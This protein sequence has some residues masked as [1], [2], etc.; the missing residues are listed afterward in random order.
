MLNEVTPSLRR[1]CM[2]REKKRSMTWCIGLLNESWVEVHLVQMLFSIVSFHLQFLAVLLI[3]LLIITCRFGSDLLCVSFFYLIPIYSLQSILC[4][5][6]RVYGFIG[7]KKADF[8]EL[9]L[10]SSSTSVINSI[11]L[12][13][14]RH[15]FHQDLRKIRF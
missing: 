6:S 1:V 15:S 2:M 12:K 5:I 11:N 13:R 10:L 8:A 9:E 3:A 4:S 14:V 7:A